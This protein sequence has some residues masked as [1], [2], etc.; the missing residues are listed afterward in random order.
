[1]FG[2]NVFDY[3]RSSLRVSVYAIIMFVEYSKRGMVPFFSFTPFVACR[4]AC[5]DGRTGRPARH[6]TK[7][8]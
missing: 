5:I 7:H 6:G 1:M 3:L 8:Y 4:M 2:Q